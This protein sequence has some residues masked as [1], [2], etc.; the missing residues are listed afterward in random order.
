MIRREVIARFLSAESDT[1]KIAELA[2]TPVNYRF[3]PNGFGEE[4][5]RRVYVFRLVPKTRKA[6][7]F[8]G[9]LWVDGQTGLPVHEA[10]PSYG[11]SFC[12]R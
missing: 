5:A 6:G 1:H 10:G 9:E 11:E 8:K 4:Q 7:L 2:I 12:I 3:Y